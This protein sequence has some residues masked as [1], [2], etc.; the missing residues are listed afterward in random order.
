M[1]LIYLLIALGST[2]IGAM[3]GLGG[4]IIIKP[5]LDVFG[6]YDLSTIG[7]LSSCTVFAMAIVSLGKKLISGFK[8]EM[9]KL[10]SM[11]M[12][13]VAG[14]IV[15]KFAFDALLNSFE[16]S[17]V[18]SSQSAMLAVLMTLI[19]IFVL[20]K[21]RIKTFEVK[22]KV[23][24]FF[25]G[26]LMGVVASFL[27]IGGGPLNVAVIYLLFS[28]DAKEA[29]IYSV[30]TIFFSQLASIGTIFLSTGFGA[31]DLTVLPYMI[32]GGIAGGFLGEFL[33]KKA[34][35]RQV[36]LMFDITLTCIIVV[37]LV[38]VF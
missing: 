4:G 19:L 35:N 23:I 27:G 6:H 29:A 16:A 12:G 11:S 7:V 36:E 15:G 9:G 32:F 18:K 26:A 24:C 13:S 33:S 20:N 8:V 17:I 21:H 25:A 38:N 1:S 34:T 14:G 10:L 5:I 31:Y 30:F 2:T 37:N 3:A 28:C 22:N